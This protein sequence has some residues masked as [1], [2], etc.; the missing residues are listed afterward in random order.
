MSSRLQHWAPTYFRA[1]SLWP[2]NTVLGSWLTRTL[3]PAHSARK[4]PASM[5][6]TQSRLAPSFGI[7]LAA[8]TAWSSTN[9]LNQRLC[10][11]QRKSGASSMSILGLVTLL[12]SNR[13]RSARG[14]Q[15]CLR[16][17][18]RVPL[19]PGLLL[20]LRRGCHIRLEKGARTQI[21]QV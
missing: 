19:L 18:G 4:T 9:D 1:N 8:M 20:P 10:T 14:R 3:G 5:G 16:C 2:Q 12:L 7:K 11:L 21:S 17:H 13:G 6:T 15:N